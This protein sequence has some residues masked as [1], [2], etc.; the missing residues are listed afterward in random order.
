[1]H[2]CNSHHLDESLRLVLQHVRHSGFRAV[3]K[4]RLDR[5]KRS[6]D[7]AKQ[8]S[9]GTVLGSRSSSSWLYWTVI[10]LL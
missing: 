3:D 5:S 1:M 2:F 9:V 4:Q 7:Q 8:S 10:N 6:S